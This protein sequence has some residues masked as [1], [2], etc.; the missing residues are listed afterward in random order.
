[1][2]LAIILAEKTASIEKELAARLLESLVSLAESSGMSVAVV[3]YGERVAPILDPTSD[4]D[5]ETL[6][7]VYESPPDLGKSPRLEEALS[8]ALELVLEYASS[9]WSPRVVTL[10]SAAVK[11][12]R[13]T[14]SLLLALE[15]AGSQTAIAALRPSLPGWIKYH[16]VIAS[17]TRTVR[18]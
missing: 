1:M 7:E 4:P 8:E 15:K 12:S 6:L 17:R 11:P 14:D 5:I 3:F 18:A 13:L 10:W 9:S 2:S 16:Q